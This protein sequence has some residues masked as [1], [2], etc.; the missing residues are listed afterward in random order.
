[1]LINQ[2]RAHE[3]ILYEQFLSSLSNKQAESQGCLYPV[4]M[5]LSAE[6]FA[7][8][9]GISENL[10]HSGFDISVFGN[11]KI[12][13]NGTPA[14]ISD[15]N[16]ESLFTD[17]I[18]KLKS[19]ETDSATQLQEELAKILASS[20]AINYGRNLQPEEMTSITDNLF[21][22]KMPNFSPSGKT[23]ISI[24]NFE[25]IEKKFK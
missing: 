21:A 2:K 1:M 17:L 6:D 16:A 18:E 14:F 19:T 15:I 25:D 10:K 4:E 9:F 24:I 22:C 23:I 7:V 12:I 5:Q 11:N 13:I 20:S 8:I 3:R